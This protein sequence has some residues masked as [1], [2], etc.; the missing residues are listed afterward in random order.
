MAETEAC[1]ITRIEVEL[2]SDTTTY[3]IR[4]Q[5]AA[6]L[7]FTPFVEISK[8]FL[9]IQPSLYRT[10]YAHSVAHTLRVI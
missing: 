8:S 9:Q 2:G 10:T 5:N 3:V 6:T 1:V 7:V 4:R